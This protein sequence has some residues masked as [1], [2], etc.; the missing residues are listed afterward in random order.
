MSVKKSFIEV[1]IDKL[2]PYE[3]NPRHNENAIP[4]TMESIRQCENLDPIEVDEDFII[5]SGHSRFEALKRLNY[6]NTE[7]V[8]YVGLTEEQKN[9]YRLL[10]N[11]TNEFAGWDEKKL[12]EELNKIDFGDFDFGFEE[13]EEEELSEEEEKKEKPEVEFTE[14]LREEHNYVVLYFDNNVDWLN[15]CSLLEIKPKNNLSTRKDGQIN[16]GMERISLGRVI[17]GAKAL[18]ILRREY[19]NQYQLPEL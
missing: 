5:L 15:L 12:Q 6:K 18:E 17:N 2:K 10:A 16:K 1:P 4:A 8:Q 7:V 11:K 19:A 3:N 13:D 14:V 9:K